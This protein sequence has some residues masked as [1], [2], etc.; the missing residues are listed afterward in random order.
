MYITLLCFSPQQITYWTLLINLCLIGLEKLEDLFPKVLVEELQKL[1]CMYQLSIWSITVRVARGEGKK[2]KTASERG[3]KPFIVLLCLL[4]SASWG[5]GMAALA[6]IHVFVSHPHTWTRPS[7]VV[8]LTRPCMKFTGMY[9]ALNRLCC[10]FVI[11]YVLFFYFLCCILFGYRLLYMFLFDLV[12]ETFVAGTR[13]SWRSRLVFGI[14]SSAT[15]TSQWL[16]PLPFGAP[17]RVP[18]SSFTTLCSP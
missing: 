14:T 10:T 15:T 1:V 3:S 13:S 6:P 17:H 18:L 8:N 11:F 4:T 7:R 12:G 16:L 9:L 2:L 5:W